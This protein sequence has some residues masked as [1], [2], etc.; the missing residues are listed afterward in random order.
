MKRIIVQLIGLTAVFSILFSACVKEDF[1]QAPVRNP[2]RGDVLTI[3]DL[4]AIYASVGE[5]Q[6]KGDSCV[7]ANVTMDDVTGNIYKSAYIQDATGAINLYLEQAG[8]FRVGDSICLY[9]KN[10]ILS[11]YSGLLQISNVQNDS[12]VIILANEIYRQP[13]VVTIPQLI[14]GGYQ[15]KLIKLEDV[16]FADFELGKIYAEAGESTNRT[17]Q[18]CDLNQVVVRT[19]GYANFA[20]D[21]VAEGKGS[22]IAIAGEYN[23]TIQ[24]YIRTINEVLLDGERCSGGGG[25]LDIITISELRAMFTGSATTIASGLGI[26]ATV[27]SDIEHDNL[28]NKNAFVQNVDGDGI[29]IRFSEA[30]N[31]EMGD[32]VEI[33]IGGQEL[34]EYNNLMQINNLANGNVKVLGTGTMPTPIEIT[35]GDLI[36][37]QEDYESQLVSLKGVTI[38]SSGGYTTYKWTT[39]LN[40]GTGT[41]DLYTSEYASFVDENFPTETVDIVGIVSYYNASQVLLRNLDD[42]VIVGGGGGGGTVDVMNIDFQDQTTYE[43]ISVAGWVNTNILGTIP[44]TARDFSGNSYAMATSYG[45]GEQVESWMI[46]NG[47]DLDALDTPRLEFE[48][49]ISYFV[50]DGLEVFISTDFN[51]S[52]I[53]AAT[54]TNLNPTLAGS[55]NANYEWVS[56]GD[57]SLSAYSG[58]AFIAFKYSGDDNSGQ[59]TSY[60]ID[61]VRVFANE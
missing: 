49:A 60:S 22:L 12:N 27:I 37:N 38:S 52:D 11:E 56:S 53:E 54:W 23:G 59:T 44:W 34:S 46:T 61:N 28:P 33:S 14:A 57:V 2:D 21:K 16:Q 7:Y 29:A 35:I 40:D 25:D 1:D 48:S 24:L 19:S 55:S 13:E 9:L 10:C 15:S 3:A 5:Y 43:N 17:L 58:T 50:Q 39:E 41:V 47:V 45:T 6:I 42:V 36:I 18:D 32:E 8:G 30:H 4:K 20:K 26:R 31:F 51:G